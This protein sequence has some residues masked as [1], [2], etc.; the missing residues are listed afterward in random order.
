MG[1]A[2]REALA[3]GRAELVRLGAD[4]DVRTGEE[5]FTV[6]QTIAGSRQLLSALTDPS[7][8]EPAKA[9]LVRGVF[10]RTLAAPTV[11]IVES[12]AGSRWSHHNDILGAIEELGIRAIASSAPGALSIETELFRFGQAVSSS[13]ELE[14][15][16]GSKLGDPAQKR[17]LIDT[18]LAAKVSE[19]SL[20]IIRHIVAQ[21]RGRSVGEALRHAAVIV[22]D[23]SNE[24]IATI[25]TAVALDDAQ[26]GRLEK[27]LSARYDRRLQLNQVVDPSIL[28]G[29]RVQ[30]GDDVIDGSIATR[31]T[32]LRLQLA[33]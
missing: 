16:L 8:T 19:Q 17:T 23:Q 3:T 28:G 32:D 33:G 10:G 15:A 2:T 1:S 11:R 18:L 30:I 26:L 9:A 5:L 25:T 12:L 7:A 31:L 13:S 22:A 4:V 24:S 21:P 27:A 6:G 20:A 29:L 14:L